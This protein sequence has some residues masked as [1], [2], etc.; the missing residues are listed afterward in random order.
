MLGHGNA[1]TSEAQFLSWK[2]LPSSM[3]E[4]VL[5]FPFKNLCLINSWEDELVFLVPSPVFRS[6][7]DCP[8]FRDS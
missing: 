8:A 4:G 5:S 1:K 3:G 6:G 2:S 7:R